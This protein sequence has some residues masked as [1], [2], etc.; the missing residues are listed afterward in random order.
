MDSAAALAHMVHNVHQC[1][2][3]VTT[4]TRVEAISVS[5]VIAAGL[6]LVINATVAHPRFQAAIA[7]FETIERHKSEVPEASEV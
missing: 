4:L 2:S 7:A 3:M 5:P 1:T 6:P